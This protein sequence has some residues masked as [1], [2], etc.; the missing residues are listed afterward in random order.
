MNRRRI[1]ATPFQNLL[2]GGT[3]RQIEHDGR[4]FYAA[5]DVVAALAGSQHPAE[6]WNDLRQSEP[7]LAAQVEQVEFPA[8]QGHGAEVSEALALEGVLRLI[9][10]I[11]S[12]AAERM[13]AWMAEAAR[14]QLE[15]LINPELAIERTRKVYEQRGFSR[16]W[17]DSRMRGIAARHELTG[18]WYKRGATES[19]HFR[20]LT[21]DLMR[22]A[23]GMDVMDYRRY[24]G[25]EGTSANLRDHMTDLELA[26]TTLGETIA[27]VL[28]RSH[29]SQ[30]F[31]QLQKDAEAAG[32]IV[33]ETRSRIE[34]QSNQSVV[35]P[36]HQ[37][38]GR[39]A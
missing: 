29:H 33:G 10:S 35:R 15:E 22:S 17:I 20:G 7:H 32:Q 2:A 8:A 6:L 18:E 37:R 39:A 5:V 30:G 24:K 4:P 16:Q 25:L 3:I 34:Q 21:N 27:T 28:H 19:E 26:L 14:Q 13:K 12:P 31:E 36:G 9:Q 1:S 23:F 11:R 38:R